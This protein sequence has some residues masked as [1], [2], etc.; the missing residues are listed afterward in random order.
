MDSSFFLWFL[1]GRNE[2][3]MYKFVHSMGCEFVCLCMY[4]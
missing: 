4:A 1:E 3:E 2:I